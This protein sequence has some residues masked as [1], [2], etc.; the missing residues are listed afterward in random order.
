MEET[1]LAQFILEFWW[2]ISSNLDF[3]SGMKQT[4]FGNNFPAHN[5]PFQS[6]ASLGTLAAAEWSHITS[7]E[8]M[9]SC[10]REGS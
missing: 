5:Y 6:L 8:L 2:V 3:C 1:V 7:Y 10:K 4:I 9:K